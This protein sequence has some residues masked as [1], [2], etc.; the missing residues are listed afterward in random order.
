ML[1]FAFNK[2]AVLQNCNF[3]TKRLQHRCI[4]ENIRKCLRTALLENISGG[5]RGKLSNINNCWSLCGKLV[6]QTKVKVELSL[7]KKFILFTSVKAQ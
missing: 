6:G 7:S 1:K 2:V 4:P 5:F 3:I